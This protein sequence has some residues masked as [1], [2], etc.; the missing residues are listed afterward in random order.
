[1]HKND[2]EKQKEIEHILVDS[3]DLLHLSVM[4]YIK[5]H[6]NDLYMNE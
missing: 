2:F 4:N 5:E 3:H 6:E 1:M